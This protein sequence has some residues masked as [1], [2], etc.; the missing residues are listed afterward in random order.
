MNKFTIIHRIIARYYLWHLRRL[1]YKTGFQ[2]PANVLREGVTIWHFGP[3]IINEY[4]SI[5]H[6]CVLNPGVIIGWKGPG[7]GAPKIGDNVFIGGSSTIIG[8]ITIGSNVII[9]PNSAVT[10]SFPSNCII[11][12]CPA[13]I[14]KYIEK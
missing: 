3:I 5:G 13:K 2:I 8:D 6:H 11:G 1:A 14:I 7:L 9:A 10:K 12:G 4:S